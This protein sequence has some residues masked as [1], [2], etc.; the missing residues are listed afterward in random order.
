MLAEVRGQV[1]AVRLD[2]AVVAVGG[3][4]LMVRATPRTLVTLRPGQTAR[5]ATSLVVREDSLTLFGF[6]TDDERDVFELLQTVSGVGP[7]LALAVLAVLD[8]DDLRRG[9][10]AGDEV[11]LMKVPGIG[12]KGAQRMLLE[13]GDRLGPPHGSTPAAATTGTPAA[14][15]DGTREQV[16][17]ALVG[18]GWAQKQSETAVDAVLDDP[19][20]DG[21]TDDPAALLRTA[22]RGLART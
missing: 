16:V 17:A 6:E 8:P 5:L 13:L 10:A 1:L 14:G 21:G 11:T 20:H 7:R 19:G 9:V 22:L 15:P 12:R 18:L 4:G 3:L 2:G